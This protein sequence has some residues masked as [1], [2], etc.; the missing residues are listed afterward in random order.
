MVETK[1]AKARDTDGIKKRSK[2]YKTWSDGFSA[3]G[4]RGWFSELV[5]TTKQ[6]QQKIDLR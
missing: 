6:R 1:E 3:K 2:N 5:K 4:N